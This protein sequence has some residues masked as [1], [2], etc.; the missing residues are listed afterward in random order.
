M[1]V[2]GLLQ[3]RLHMAGFVVAGLDDFS[4]SSPNVLK[5][6]ATLGVDVSH[7]TP[8]DVRDKGAL[9]QVF[10]G[11]VIDAVVH[12]AAYKAVAESVAQPL[13]YYANNVGGLIALA[14]VMQEHSCKTIVFSSSATV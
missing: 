2:G 7:F 13:A 12:F 8:A 4:N 11:G 1:R 9:G 10:A 3:G 6:L 14:Q 5:R